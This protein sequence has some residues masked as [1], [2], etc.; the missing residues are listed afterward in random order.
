M[1]VHRWKIESDSIS[2]VVVN[3]TWSGEIDKSLEN[4]AVFFR[5]KSGEL[6]FQKEDYTT[7]KDAPD[8]ELIEV[9]LE[10]KCDASWVEQWRGTFT[11]YDC[12]FDE[13]KCVA[14]VTPKPKDGYVC[15][16]DGWEIDRQIGY[17]SPVSVRP[18]GGTYHVGFCCSDCIPSASAPPS[19]PVC[20]TPD[21]W[22]YMGSE[23]SPAPCPDGEERWMSC[24]HRIIGVGTPTT[25]PPYGTGWTY[26]SGNDWWR[27]PDGDEIAAPPFDQGRFFNERI[28]FLVDELGCG[29]TVRSHFFGINA[30][31]TAPPSNDAYDFAT[32]NLQALQI[33]QKSDI[34]RPFAT[35]PARDFV[36]KMNLKKLLEDFRVKFN[37]F[38]MIDG[39]DMIIE[40]ISYF[41]ET[42]G[43]D[44]T[45][46]N[47]AIEYGKQEASAPNIEYFKWMDAEA[48][49]TETHRGW[50]ISYGDCGEGKKE[51]RVNYFS[52]DIFYISTVENQEEIADAGFCLIAT[53]EVDGEN[54]IIGNNECLGWEQL[55]ENL[56]K[57]RR[58]FLEGNMNDTPAT[59]FLSTIKTRKLNEFTVKVCCDDDFSLLDSIDTL[60]GEASVQKASFNYFTGQNAVMVKIDANV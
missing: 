19:G 48:T 18:F 8:C 13:N 42:I 16:M 52:N 53:E 31:H 7:I 45:T 60:A 57:H 5:A 34:K 43:L 10:Q 35:N 33:H 22:C 11:T 15:L 29:L 50:P 59:T 39:T 23:Y 30:T 55:H 56:H 41:S 21:D 51:N 58:F 2:A 47:I 20:A 44:M 46:S 1:S 38:W 6:K 24:F 40:H 17:G 54:V 25:P 32:A 4:D 28:E 9:Y 27:C 12:K 49:F 14:R 26:I 3:P 37:V 36:W